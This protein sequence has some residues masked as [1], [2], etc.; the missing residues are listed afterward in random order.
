M[1]KSVAKLSLGAAVLASTLAFGFPT[2]TATK[3]EV[4][5]HSPSNGLNCIVECTNYDINPISPGVVTAIQ[6]EAR[7]GTGF[8]FGVSDVFVEPQGSDDLVAYC[9]MGLQFVIDLEDAP[10]DLTWETYTT[11]ATP[12]H[13]GFVAFSTPIIPCP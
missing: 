5:N 4:L 2:V 11:N 6:L 8:S 13:A 10:L 9:S 3:R 7:I 12:G 1:I